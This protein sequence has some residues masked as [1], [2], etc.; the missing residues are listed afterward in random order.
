MAHKEEGWVR[1][2]GVF[3]GLSPGWSL[4]WVGRQATGRVSTIEL[5]GGQR[6]QMLVP[7]Q[8]PGLSIQAEHARPFPNLPLG[9]GG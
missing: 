3:T 9:G 7:P 8:K 1:L 4:P 2:G 6:G 5:E